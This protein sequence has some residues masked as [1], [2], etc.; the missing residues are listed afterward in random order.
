MLKPQDESINDQVFCRSPSVCVRPDKKSH[1]FIYVCV[2]FV[3]QEIKLA[4]LD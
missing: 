2:F 4:H 1:W 3:R